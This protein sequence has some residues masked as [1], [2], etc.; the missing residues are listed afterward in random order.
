MW[1]RL[2]S[3]VQNS[4][5]FC[6]LKQQMLPE[7]KTGL[8]SVLKNSMRFE[9]QHKDTILSTHMQ[10]CSWRT[11]LRKQRKKVS[12][13]TKVKKRFENNRTASCAAATEAASLR[14]SK[15]RQWNKKLFAQL[16]LLYFQPVF[17]H[18]LW[19]LEKLCTKQWQWKIKKNWKLTR[20]WNKFCTMAEVSKD[21]QH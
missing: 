3:S 9:G 13:S 8:F 1:F 7:N 4:F 2:P 20:F 19:Y 15:I 17:W 14:K 11:D 5:S 12:F 6:F 18:G 21:W 10:Y 16:K